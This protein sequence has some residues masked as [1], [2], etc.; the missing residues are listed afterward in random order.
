MQTFDCL[1]L[2]SQLNYRQHICYTR[3]I[4]STFNE[5]VVRRANASAA[6]CGGWLGQTDGQT[7]GRTPDRFIDPA[8]L[9]INQCIRQQRA[10]GHLQ[11]AMYNIQ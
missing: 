6:G 3:E 7:D 5:A 1:S 8:P 4:I 10:K 2:K 11:V 9:T